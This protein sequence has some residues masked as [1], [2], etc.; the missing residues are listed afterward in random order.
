[1]MRL[2]S[3]RGS[4]WVGPELKAHAFDV[5][6]LVRPRPALGP[7]VG[8]EWVPVAPLEFSAT[9]RIIPT[10]GTPAAFAALRAIFEAGTSVS[11]LLDLGGEPRRIDEVLLVSMSMD[12]R[13]PARAIDFQ[14]VAPWRE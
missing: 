14:I 3:A 11:F 8:G 6:A 5:R 10:T 1:M 12:P 7:T 4:F 9:G 2:T 13:D